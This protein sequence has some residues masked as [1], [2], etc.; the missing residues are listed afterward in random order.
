MAAALGRVEAVEML[1]KYGYTNN[2]TDKFGA[3][4]AHYAAKKCVKTLQ[5]I[6]S[7][8]GSRIVRFHLCYLYS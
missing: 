7:L 8:S 6:L 2:T 3:T 4:P 1:M 5:V